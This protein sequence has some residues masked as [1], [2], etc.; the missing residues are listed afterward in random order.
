MSGLPFKYWLLSTSS[1]VIQE[2]VVARS[3]TVF[4]EA[5]AIVWS[6]F[7]AAIEHL[8]QLDG[9]IQLTEAWQLIQVVRSAQGRADSNFVEQ[10]ASF[11]TIVTLAAYSQNQDPRDT[12]YALLSL[13]REDEPPWTAGID[14]SKP[15]VEVAVNFVLYAISS[16]KSLNIICRPWIVDWGNSYPSWIR[17]VKPLVNE[18]G[19][20]L[21]ST[22]R[23]A[24]SFVGMPGKCK[25]K[26][27]RGAEPVVRLE[28]GALTTNGFLFDAIS[29]VALP[30]PQ[31]PARH[32]SGDFMNLYQ[33]L[34]HQMREEDA[35]I[36]G[37]MESDEPSASIQNVLNADEI[38]EVVA[39][40][41]LIQMKGMV[42]GGTA[43]IGLAPPE[44]R[45]GDCVCLLL[46][47]DVPVI[48]R[49]TPGSGYELIGEAF[50]AGVMYGEGMD[51]LKT[52]Q[53][54]IREIMIG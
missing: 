2:L 43:S 10:P 46:G 39:G 8:I 38:V 37:S 5:N 50:I 29:D 21:A 33:Y 14:Y 42:S 9:Q 24:D 34:R 48:L 18:R 35:T 25:Y 41:V 26:A 17:S 45:V 7:E 40:R 36:S 4:S 31:S 54:T 28:Y 13:I 3:A 20:H 52:G 16:S 32:T 23:I 12:I 1:W 19:S 11:E 22:R 51:G 49:P 15:F 53:Y 6:D 30:D 47:C 44:S 27:T